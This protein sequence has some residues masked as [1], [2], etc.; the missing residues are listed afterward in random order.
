MEDVNRKVKLPS[1]GI[2]KRRNKLHWERYKEKL[3]GSIDTAA[4]RGMGMNVGVMCTIEQEKLGL[5]PFYVKRSLGLVM[6]FRRDTLF[7]FRF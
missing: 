3:D 6:I 1:K 7:S 4:I 2:S 5:S